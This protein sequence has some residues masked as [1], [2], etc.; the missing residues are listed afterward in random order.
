MKLFKGNKINA[1]RSFALFLI[2][3]GFII[4]YIGIFF[5]DSIIISTLF[6]ILGCFSILISTIIYLWIGLLS[7][8]THQVTCPS[9]N[10]ATKMLGKVD[11]CM[12]CD[13]PLLWIEI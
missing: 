11:K 12:H 13:H 8:R 4:M 7:T 9:C 10:K 1:I 3:T 5:R 6:M 2:F